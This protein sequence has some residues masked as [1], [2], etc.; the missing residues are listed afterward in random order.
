MK[1]YAI[2]I[3]VAM[4]ML[5][6]CGKKG[7]EQSTANEAPMRTAEQQGTIESERPLQVQAETTNPDETKLRPSIDQVPP[8]IEMNN[9]MPKT[10]QTMSVDHMTGEVL[11]HD[12]GLAL[13]KKSGCLACHKIETKLVG[14]AWHDVSVRYKGDPEAKSRLVA[15]VK[16]GGKGNWT[17]ITGGISMPPYS[18]RVS[19]DDI[20]ILVTFVLSQ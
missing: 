18:P 14:P 20:D 8:S 17:A 19:D 13:A 16:S 3:I 7:E 1:I 12:E 2:V 9:V 4:L 6:G 5:S 15:K 11:G 10:Q